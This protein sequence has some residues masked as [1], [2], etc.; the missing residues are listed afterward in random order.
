M[1][2]GSRRRRQPVIV[3]LTKAPRIGRGK[4]RLAAGVGPVEAWRIN[5]ALQALTFRRIADPRWRVLIAVDRARDLRLR[6]PGIWPPVQIVA[7]ARGDLGARIVAGLAIGSGP[8]AVIGTDCPGIT[9]SAVAAVFAGL[10]RSRFAAGPAADGGFWMLAARTGRNAAPLAAGV[11]W[12]SAHTLSDVEARLGPMA[13]GP[14]LA[15]IDTADDWRAY[16]RRR[17]RRSLRAT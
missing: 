11:R 3:V 2:D 16:Q 17:V 1:R 4:S 9:R 12:S 10:R 6:L 14:K 5:R 15:D 8:V 7:Q 13:R